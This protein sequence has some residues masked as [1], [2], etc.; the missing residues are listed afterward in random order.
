M[1]YHL[2]LPAVGIIVGIALIVAHAFAWLQPMNCGRQLKAFP[3]SRTAG[4]VL[5]GIA[6]LWSL[7]LV[8]QMDLGEFAPMRKILLIGSVAGAFLAWKYVEEFLAVRALGMIMLLLA[9]PVLEVCYLR[10]EG[11]RLVLVVLAYA[12]IIAGLFW[13][14]M[15]WVLRDQI[16]WVT[17]TV[18]RLRG[19]ALGG[20]VYGFA[21]V[22]C[23]VLF[24]R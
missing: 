16:K 21:I 20:V 17:T 13:V 24:W 8:S 14:G 4:T 19:A 12:W 9:E 15:P 1:I 18:S 10:P 3:R 11:S 6:G 7:I 23:A 5:I 2:S 22:V